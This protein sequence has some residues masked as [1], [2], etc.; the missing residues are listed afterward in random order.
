MHA[1]E[2]MPQ[3]PAISMQIGH[4]DAQFRRTFGGGA[5]PGNRD[6]TAPIRLACEPH[7]WKIAPLAGLDPELVNC[8]LAPIT[9]G[10]IGAVGDANDLIPAEI[11]AFARPIAVTKASV[12]QKGDPARALEQ[13]G[14]VVKHR[15][16]R[17]EFHIP[18]ACDHLPVQW[19]GAIAM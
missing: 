8:N 18:F 16:A 9:E 17:S 1:F 3:H 2:I 4:H 14:D 10:D 13:H 19:Q 11:A 7:V 6:I 12:G 15:I 5:C